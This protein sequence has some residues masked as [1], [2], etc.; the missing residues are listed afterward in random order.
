MN[1][2][3][4]HPGSPG[5]LTR[6]RENPILT[7]NDWPYRIHTVFNP[8]AIRLQDGTTLLLCRV[9]DYQGHSHLTVA[10][11][12]NG[13]DNW[14]IDPAP[15]MVP[16]PGTHPEEK[17]GIEDPRIT[18]LEEL[19]KY[20]IAYTAYGQHGPLVSL[21]LTEDFKSFERLGP[22]TL[23]S[24]KDAA[25]LPRKIGGEWVLIHRPTIPG[26]SSSIWISYSPDLIHWGKHQVMLEARTGGWWDAHKIGLSPPPIDTDEG[27][28][29]MYHG[30]RETASGSIYRIGLALF[31]KEDPV[32]CIRRGDEWIMTAEEPYEL[33]GDVGN[34]V[35]PCG[36]TVNGDGDTIHVYY[37]GADSCIAVATGS[38]KEMLAWLKD[39]S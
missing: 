32:R 23:A 26:D 35:F 25:V 33:F 28:L 22:A 6:Y 39:H 19:G 9:E 11:S 4:R 17:W 1:R 37:G 24:N 16:E 21:A 12:Q 7:R 20:C 34:V 18:Y 27:F 3:N 14:E 5:L 13:L 8:A 30:I 36:M 29:V 10:R 31:D 15:S 2:N 38:I